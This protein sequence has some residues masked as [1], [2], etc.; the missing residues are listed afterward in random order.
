MI[1]GFE[2][3]C[4]FRSMAKSPECPRCG[5]VTSPKKFSDEGK[6]L[7]FI[8]LGILPEH[9]EKPENLVMVEI[10]DGPKLICWADDNL[11]EGQRVRVSFEDGLI[12]CKGI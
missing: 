10:D 6:V 9:H 12:I 1:E 11:A 3:K 2:C 7:S 5:R 8:Q 4:G